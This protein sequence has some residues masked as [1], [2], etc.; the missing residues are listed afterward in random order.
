MNQDR[1]LAPFCLVDG[2]VGLGILA[3]IYGDFAMEWQPVS[4]WTTDRADPFSCRP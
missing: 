4:S 3:I 1:R 2:F